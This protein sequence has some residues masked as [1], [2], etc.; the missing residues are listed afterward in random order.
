[1]KNTSRIRLPYVEFVPRICAARTKRH[2]GRG[3][4]LIKNKLQGMRIFNVVH[5]RPSNT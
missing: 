5:K 2:Y 1:M 3:Y 4:F